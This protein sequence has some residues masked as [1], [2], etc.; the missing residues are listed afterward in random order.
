VVMFSTM[1]LSAFLK[2]VN[3][4]SP[5]QVVFACKLVQ[6]FITDEEAIRAERQQTLIQFNDAKPRIEEFYRAHPN[7]SYS[8]STVLEEAGLPNTLLNRDRA[9]RFKKQLQI[10]HNRPTE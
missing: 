2:H 8:E 4:A 5:D 10:T 1:P 9:R 3:G 7:G 6:G